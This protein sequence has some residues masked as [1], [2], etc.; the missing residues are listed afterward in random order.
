[1]NE[2][3]FFERIYSGCNDDN[4]KTIQLLIARGFLIEQENSKYYISDNSHKADTKY[5]DNILKK[6]EIG[7]VSEEKIVVHNP[8]HYKCIEQEFLLG[9]RLGGETSTQ[10]FGWGYFARHLH[11]Y[12][13]SVEY[14][15]PYIASY[16]KAIS[17]AGVITSE[18]C[19]GNHDN[20]KRLFVTFAGEP[21]YVWHE[22][23]TE[24][25]AH[26][27]ITIPWIRN[28]IV[29]KNENEQY[30]IYY[31]L[32]RAAKFVYTNRIILRGI[33]WNAL[34]KYPRAYLDRMSKEEV[35]EI[36][37]GNS[38]QSLMEKGLL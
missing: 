31:L 36:F 18:A 29:W 14:L 16:V 8:Y 5:L 1:M 15:E 7:E 28:G 3:E 22:I 6:Y 10:Y 33:K 11:G 35:R 27:D 13:V 38:K 17:S 32:N 4:E 19:D 24:V 34:E 30:D 25:L 37:V 2:K 26:H 21:S 20:L 9:K 23:I 12:K